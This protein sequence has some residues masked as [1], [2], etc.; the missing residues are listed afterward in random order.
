M[1][2]SEANVTQMFWQP[3]LIKLTR[4]THPEVPAPQEMYVD[5]QRIMTIEADVIVYSVLEPPAPLPEN[6]TGRH[7]KVLATKI[8]IY[9]GP[10][11]FSAESPT[12]V[13]E[14][15]DKALGH[16]EPEGPPT[17]GIRSVK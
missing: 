4:V 10:P 6:Y 11:V 7:P 16:A 15:R 14:I 2:P 5:P 3:K 17:V 1:K 12:E 8:S 9:G 13:D